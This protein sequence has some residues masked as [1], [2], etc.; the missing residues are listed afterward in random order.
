M[1]E[2]SKCEELHQQEYSGCVHSSRHSNIYRRSHGREPTEI[3]KLYYANADK[4]NDASG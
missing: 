4:D 3:N 1:T 2:I